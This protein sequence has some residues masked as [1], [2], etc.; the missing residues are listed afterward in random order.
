[1]DKFFSKKIGSEVSHVLLEVMLPEDPSPPPYLVAL[2]FI[3]NNV[4]DIN[5]TIGIAIGEFVAINIE[6]KAWEQR[7][8]DK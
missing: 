8:Q 6:A 5:P 4:L 2:M 7:L 1:M 3:T